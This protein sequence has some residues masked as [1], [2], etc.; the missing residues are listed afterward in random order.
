MK[1][2]REIAISV[3][4][5]GGSARAQNLMVSIV[6]SARQQVVVSVDS[7]YLQHST[8]NILSLQMRLCLI[9]MP[10]ESQHR[11]TVTPLL[12][13]STDTARFTPLQA[14]GRLA[15][16]HAVRAGEAR[17]LQYRD[18]D[19]RTPQTYLQQIVWQPWMNGATLLL[20]IDCGDGC[21]TSS[22]W[23]S[24]H[25][26]L[27]PKTVYHRRQTAD[28]HETS[29][30]RESGT[31]YIAFPVNNSEVLPAFGNNKFELGRLC[32]VID[33]INALSHVTINS[34]TIKGFAS[35]EGSY[36]NNERLAR[37][38]TANLG[39]YLSDHCSLPDSLL[40]SSSEAEDWEGLRR[41]VGSDTYLVNRKAIVAIIDTDMDPDARLALIAKQHPYAYKYIREHIFPR[42][43]HTDYQ[44][45]YTLNTVTTHSG[46]VVTDSTLLLPCQTTDAP[47]PAA[48]HHRFRTFRPWL[49][50]KTNLLYDLLVAPN[51]EVE[52]PLGRQGRWSIM[53]EYNNPWWRWDRKSQSYEIQEG[54]LELRRWFAPQC[55]ESRPWLSGHFWA[56]YGAVAKYDLERNDVGDQG[57]VISGGLTYGYSWP[58]ARRWNLEASVSAGAVWGRRR[59]YNAEF[60]S[61]HLIYKYTK[62]LFYAGP[63]K[64]KLSLVWMIGK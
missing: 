1:L 52:V 7:L 3:I 35:P 8:D 61:T 29:S 63:T 11:L 19:I 27:E 12:C 54:G 25:V 50:L 55:N 56:V 18:R 6:H 48:A 42:L 39:C 58:I 5:L 15:Y 31:S 13:T 21:S 38:R 24:S 4:L 32:H 23:H 46:A 44:I 20:N 37:E 14:Y 40:H 64:L 22:S 43:R 60:E 49:A 30:R 47:A 2:L 33:S 45:D 26:A 51:I 34:V 9:G 59:H 36:Q 28:W 62:N 17:S 57:E 10:L 53:A 41:L 16:Y